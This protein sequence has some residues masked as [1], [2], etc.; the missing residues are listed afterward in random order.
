MSAYL[1]STYLEVTDTAKLRA[2]A[3][4]ATPAILDAGGRFL[5]RDVA[6]VA[7]ESGRT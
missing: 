6:A 2:Y 3:E 7:Y 4:L 1:V 5:A